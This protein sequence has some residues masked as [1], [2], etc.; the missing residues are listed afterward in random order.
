MQGDGL[1]TRIYGMCHKSKTPVDVI[2]FLNRFRAIFTKLA[3]L[4]SNMHGILRTEQL[5]M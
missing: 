2:F 5:T 3:A 4:K 1:Y